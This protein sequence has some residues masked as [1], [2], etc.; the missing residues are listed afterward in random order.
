MLLYLVFAAT[1]SLSL[2]SPF[3]I[4]GYWENWGP[5][6]S[7]NALQNY[8]HI[9]YSFLETESSS[10]K[11]STPEPSIVKFFHDAG[12]SVLGSVGGASMNN[13]WKDCNVNSM[14]TDLVNIV[15]TY[16]LDG[17]DID[18]EVDPPNAQFVVGLNNGLRRDLPAGKLI[19]HV[20]ENNLMDN[21][22]SYWKILQ[23]CQGVDF[24]SIQYY[25]DNPNPLTNPAGAVAHYKAV[26]SDIFQGNASKVVFGLCISDCK[27]YNMDASHAAAIT[28]TLVEAY[29]TSFGGIMNWAE[30]EGD[31][32]GEWSAAVHRNFPKGY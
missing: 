16:D 14:V 15:K 6:P 9:I 29:P 20:P 19:T 2:S 21:G 5:K 7:A 25:N 13:Y 12:V 18:Y 28:K 1:L 31:I 30:N 3:K 32:N 23:Q 17:I 22:A 4:V 10:C 26:V 24:I 11:L 27:G 8:T